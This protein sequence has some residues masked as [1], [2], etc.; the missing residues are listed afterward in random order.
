[1]EE[2]LK[3]P[4]KEIIPI[5]K[6]SLAMRFFMKYIVNKY[7]MTILGFI[8]WMIFYDNNSYLVINELN[9]AINKYEQER[10]YY[11]SEYEKND[12]LYRKLMFIKSEKERF[13]RENYF[14]KKPDEQ[15]FI[16]VADSTNVSKNK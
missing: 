4:K 13:A 12:S 1:M 11:K 16:L 7:T 15:I 2:P 5:K 6:K 10:A 3:T 14:M 9:G 8:V